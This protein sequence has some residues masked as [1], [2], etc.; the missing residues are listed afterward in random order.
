LTLGLGHLWKEKL[1]LG[2][3]LL[4][5]VHQTGFTSELPKYYDG[6]LEEMRCEK[7]RLEEFFWL[8]FD[9]IHLG[10]DHFVEKLF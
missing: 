1:V 2:L 4:K 6:A 9:S 5:G 7:M 3:V 8:T 10:L